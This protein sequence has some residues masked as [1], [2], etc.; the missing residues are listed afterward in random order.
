MIDYF[1][2]FTTGGIVLWQ[3]CN[4]PV[5]AAIVDSLVSDIFIEDRTRSGE[6]SSLT[7][8]RY[9]V[10]WTTANDFGIIIVAVYQSLLQI[11]FIDELLAS[12]KKLFTT[13]YG[14]ELTNKDPE[15]LPVCKFDDYFA[16]RYAELEIL[17]AGRNVGE[18][19]NE[20]FGEKFASG[21]ESDDVSEPPSRVTSS[22]SVGDPVKAEKATVKKPNLSK[23]GGRRGGRGGPTTRVGRESPFGS[24]GDE[25]PTKKSGKKLRKWDIDGS[26]RDISD[27][28]G[29]LDFSAGNTNGNVTANGEHSD[30]PLLEDENVE[31]WGSK[32]KSGEFILKDLSSEINSILAAPDASTTA[33]GTRGASAALA[34][35]F[36]FFRNI[37][38]NKVL[39]EQDLDKALAAM[40]DHLM[41]KNVAP[42]VAQHLCDVVSKSLVGTKTGNW[43]SI[44]KTVRAAMEAA[45]RRI[46]TPSTSVDLLHEIQRV[47]S[48]NPPR[49]YVISVVGVNG[50]G[51]ST[52]LSKIAFWLL[53]NNMKLL[54]AACDTFRSGAVEQL[55]VHARNLKKLTERE[56]G[57]IELFEKGYGKDAAN[58]ARDAITYG[59][60]HGFDVVLIDT[61]GRRH[62]DT[63]LMSSLE[64]FAKY[65]NPDKIVMVGEALVGTDSVQ[66]ARN[67]NAAFGPSRNLD[68][69]LISKCDTVG[70][71]IGSMVN[72]TYSTGIPVLFVGT[73]QMYTDLRTLSVPWAVNMLMA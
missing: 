2:V 6:Q 37:I 38:G 36:G 62:N 29:P 4:Q 19:I 17:S 11:S 65:A 13:L 12:V 32:T 55:R 41:K 42:E 57:E 70:D 25:V 58:I 33:D 5:S 23:R 39:N 20:G 48:T 56:G 26:A 68:F 22:D 31:N 50:V 21:D 63:R 30:N 60:E 8:D 45:L 24:S 52:N 54:I 73:G 53:Q 69:F 27:D 47:K 46:L 35:G 64:K 61:A 16:V 71:M 7:K 44:E 67:F 18:V 1:T 34:S 15:K 49:P 66:Q 43:T 72:M 51:K 59:R 10:K 9:T 3:K 40:K 14:D 28:E